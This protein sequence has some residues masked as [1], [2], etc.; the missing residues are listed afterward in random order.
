MEVNYRHDIISMRGDAVLENPYKR[1]PSAS[2]LLP[3]SKGRVIHEIYAP[4]VL[5]SYIAPPTHASTH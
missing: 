4:K 3:R 1:I 2:G 5:R